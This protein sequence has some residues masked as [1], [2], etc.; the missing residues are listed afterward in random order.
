MC[1]SQGLSRYKYLQVFRDG[2]GSIASPRSYSNLGGPEAQHHCDDAVTVNPNE[3]ID[4]NLDLKA[5]AELLLEVAG[6]ADTGLVI[7]VI[8][9]ETQVEISGLPDLDS[10][11]GYFYRAE[12]KIV[13]APVK[14]SRILYGGRP[15]DSRQAQF[16]F[17]C[18][19]KNKR[20]FELQRITGAYQGKGKVNRNQ[21]LDA[22]HLWCAEHNGCDFFLSLDFTLAKVI[23]KSKGKPKVPVVRPSQLLTAVRARNWR[24]HGNAR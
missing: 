8:T 12:C 4:N 14:Y 17:L 7:F 5:E 22:F 19:L 24:Q 20:F 16:N 11:T 23:E 2:A 9:I 1:A 10:E 3:G 18:S 21:L 13:D 15:D 6:L